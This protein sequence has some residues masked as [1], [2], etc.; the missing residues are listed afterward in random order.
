MSF[1]KGLTTLK[2]AVTLL[3]ALRMKISQSCDLTCVHRGIIKI[4]AEMQM[5]HHRV[6]PCV[7][8]IFYVSRWHHV[9]DYSS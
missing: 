3:F 2:V 7:C 4:A 1:P 9:R 5:L 6:F 8:R